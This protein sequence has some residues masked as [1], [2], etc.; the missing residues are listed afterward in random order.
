MD[1]YVAKIK[2]Q[3]GDG[4]PYD[5]KIEPSKFHEIFGQISPKLSEILQHSSF[6]EKA[7]RYENFDKLAIKEQSKFKRSAFEATLAICLSAASGSVLTGLSLSQFGPMLCTAILFSLGFISA[8]GGAWAAFRLYQIRHEKLLELWMTSRAKAETERLSY[9]NSVSRYLVKKYSADTS[10][11]LFFVFMFKRYQLEVQ[12]I[13]YKCRSDDHRQSLTITSRIGGAAAVLLVVGS[14]GFGMIGAFVPKVLPFAALGTIGAAI[15]A[16]AS[17]REE[18]NQDERSYERYTRT[19]DILSQIAEMHD[20]V[21][22]IVASGHSADVII[23]YVA[24]V[25]DQLSLEHRQWTSD[26]SEMSSA[27]SAL[28]ESLSGIR[29]E[30]M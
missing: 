26:S 4:S 10:V 7:K 5:Y 16:F 29:G 19:S 28:E 12:R 1:K 14:G 9:F 3:I 8:G 20:D 6:Q 17:R 13:Y 25:N 21:V 18:I 24:A 15:A 23:K 2:K 27:L 30:S 22:S 11:L